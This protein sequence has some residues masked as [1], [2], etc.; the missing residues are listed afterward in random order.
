MPR[1][2]SITGPVARVSAKVVERIEEAMRL[3]PKFIPSAAQA[4]VIVLL[5]KAQA[6]LRTN[7]PTPDEEDERP[8]D[9]VLAGIED[10]EKST[11]HLKE[12]KA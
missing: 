12:G 1:P 5:A 10:L 3:D 8:G 11:E 9:Q 6:I 2:R 4:Q 7:K